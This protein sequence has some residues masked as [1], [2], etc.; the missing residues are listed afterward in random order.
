MNDVAKIREHIMRIASAGRNAGCIALTVEV[1]EVFDTHCTV[2]LGDMKLTG[3]RLYSQASEKGNILL[4][5]KKGTMATVLTDTD[6]RDMEII[7][8]DSISSMKFEENGLI[9]EYDSEAGKIQI[10][11]NQ[12]SLKD[13]FQQLT[14][15]IRSLKVGVLAPNSISGPVDPGTMA[16]AVKFETS[17]KQL[18]K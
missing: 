6:F 16:S 7:K 4:K 15:M 2:Q 13:L 8:A 18:L 3:V 12:V 10:K 17:F 5:P 14:D 9:I 1:I 11:N